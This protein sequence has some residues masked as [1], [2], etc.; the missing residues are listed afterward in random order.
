MQTFASSITT[1]P[2]LSTATQD[3]PI[4]INTYNGNG[5]TIEKKEMFL[6]YTR[7]KLIGYFDLLESTVY[8]GLPQWYSISFSIPATAV[9]SYPF[10]RLV[11]SSTMTFSTPIQC[12]ST[13]ILPFNATGMQFKIES[14]QSVVFW[15]IKQLTAGATYQ[16]NCRL[17]TT[18]NKSATAITPTISI[19]VHHNYT[20]G[21]SYVATV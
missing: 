10:I 11:L 13:T 15:N 16:L 5:V 3:I 19:E 7:Q 12:N 4:Y 8:A 18:A 6:I 21:N 1:L 2:Y 17:K 9:S 14:A 20:V